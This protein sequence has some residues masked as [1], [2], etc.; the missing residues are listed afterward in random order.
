M[1]ITLGGFL[2]LAVLLAVAAGRRPLPVTPVILGAVGDAQ[3]GVITRDLRGVGAVVSTAGRIAAPG[4]QVD[5]VEVFDEWQTVVRVTSFDGVSCSRSLSAAALRLAP[6][7]DYE[8]HG[9]IEDAVVE[10]VEGAVFG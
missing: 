4:F 6:S 2:L 5:L 3:P 7:A 9:L 10:L 8:V 1:M